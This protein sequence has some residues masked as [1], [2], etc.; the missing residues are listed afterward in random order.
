MNKF[1]LAVPAVCDFFSST[2]HYIALNFISGSVYQM[3]RGGTIVTTFLFAITFLKL[4]IKPNQVIGSML[5]LV[6]VVVVGVSN[7]VFANSSSSSSDTVICYIFLD[8]TA[9]WVRIDNNL[10]IL[11]RILLCVLAK[12]SA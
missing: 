9:D 2:L 10:V 5:A 12:A 4:K 11:H 3:L 6:G 7:V 8:N 1:L